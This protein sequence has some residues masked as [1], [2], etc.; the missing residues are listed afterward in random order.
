MS[1]NIE[2]N[3]LNIRLRSE[4]KPGDIGWI[5]ERHGM[6]YAEQFAWNSNFEILVAK[7]VANFFDKFQKQFEKFWFA[8]INEKKVGFVLISKERFR[9]LCVALIPFKEM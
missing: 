5:I 1:K 4:L 9:V 3:N 2:N 8:E 7:I 6:I